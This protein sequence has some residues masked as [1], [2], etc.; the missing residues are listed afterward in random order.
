[1][2]AS[3]LSSPLAYAAMQVSPWFCISISVTLV[4]IALIV[5]L[6]VP[7]TK[8]VSSKAASSR[9]VA[10]T[11][12]ELTPDSWRSALSRGV[13]ELGAVLRYQF[14]G[15]LLLGTTLFTVIFTTMGKTVSNVLMQYAAKRF[16]WKWEEANLLNG[17]ILGVT[18]IMTTLVLPTL[19]TYLKKR[20]SMT[21][22]RKDLT[23]VR[24]SFFFL[25][26]GALLV[27]FSQTRALLTASLVVYGLGTANELSIRALVAQAA[28][29][30]AATIFT[31]MTAVEMLGMAGAAPTMA[32]LL[33]KGMELGGLWR[34][35]PFFVA[36]LIFFIA[37]IIYSVVPFNLADR[38]RS[39]VE[40]EQEEDN[41]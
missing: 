15:N 10:G 21:L 19:D 26:I 16:H 11:E 38:T 41:D 9:D 32:A 12:R 17:L 2:T 18:I 8:P 6:F 23:L 27:G 31:T 14:F 5:I 36:S 3:L 30:R 7:E 13:R 40:P 35:L 20:P 29:D 4:L 34:G 37:T 33:S 25:F 39:T 24:L 28:G 1:M 22:L